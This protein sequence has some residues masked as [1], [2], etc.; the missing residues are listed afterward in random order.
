VALHNQLLRTDGLNIG[1]QRGGKDQS[2]WL[3]PLGNFEAGDLPRVFSQMPPELR[4]NVANVDADFSLR[5]RMPDRPYTGP[6]SM[7][8]RHVLCV[9][10]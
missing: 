8:V 6:E 2:D 9:S 7:T 3:G 10:D 4:L 1:W 5:E